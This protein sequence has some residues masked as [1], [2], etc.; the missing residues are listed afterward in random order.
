MDNEPLNNKILIFYLEKVINKL[1]RN[2]ISDY[3][4]EKIY[5]IIFENASNCDVDLSNKESKD[6]LSYIFLGWYI[7]ENLKDNNLFSNDKDVNI[8]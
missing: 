2:E 1:K 5:K 8:D 3:D 7:N 6:I 4:L